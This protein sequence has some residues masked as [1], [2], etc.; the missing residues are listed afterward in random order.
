[1]SS[2]TIAILTGASRGLG[3]AMALQLITRDI[4]LITIARHTNDTLSDKTLENNSTL[5]QLEIDL[6]DPEAAQ[7]AGER[8]ATL[9]PKDV[10]HCVLIN[11]A[12]TVQPVADTMRLSDATAI[13]AALT[14]NVTSIMLLCSAVLQA[15]K[16]R[17]ADCR[18]LNISSGAGRSAMPGWA[19][20]CATKAALDMYTQ[21]LAQEHPDTRAV[22]LAPG[23]IDTAMQATIRASK[24][25]DFPNVGRFIQM[26]EQGQLASPTDTARHILDFLD[27]DDFGTTVLD[28]IRNYI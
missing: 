11:N 4:P 8:V 13:T 21:V 14:L 7:D 16:T 6:S 17:E 22:S 10:S 12:G 5:T 25:Q 2:K 27:R 26:H 15:C 20:Y 19:V 9:I 28:D 23:I 3:E 24:A 18:I 1:M